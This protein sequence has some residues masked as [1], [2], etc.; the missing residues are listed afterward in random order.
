M[1]KFLDIFKSEDNEYSEGRIFAIVGKAILCYFMVAYA[2]NLLNDWI[3]FTT[4]VT[5][6]IAPKLFE[7]VLYLKISGAPK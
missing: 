7:K 2:D 1:S 4:I 6:L 5:A 3:M